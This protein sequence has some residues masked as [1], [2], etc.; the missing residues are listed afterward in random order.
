MLY[1]G[2]DLIE[3]GRMAAALDR[4][5]DR[6]LPRVFTPREIAQCQGRVESL[7]ARFAAKEAA[8]K[9]LGTGVWRSNI[10]WTDIETVRDEQTGAPTLQLHGGPGL[11]GLDRQPLPRPH[12]RHRAGRRRELTCLRAITRVS[13]TTLASP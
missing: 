13:G 7:A 3:I 8:A 1:S 10:I 2:V 9:A 5:A 4:H 12:P 6:L 11:A